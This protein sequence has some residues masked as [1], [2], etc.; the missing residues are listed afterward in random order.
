MASYV[1]SALTKGE[2]VVYQGKV[3]IWSLAPLIVLGFIF[4][5]FY[6]LGLLFWAAAAIRYL[7]TELAI[8][9]KRVI[10][11]FG[12]ISRSTIEINLQKIES[13]QVNQGILGRVFNFGSIVVS[14]A[15]NPQAPI[16]G[17]SSP[18]QFRRAFVDTQESNGQPQAVAQPA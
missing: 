17:I 2:Q 14:G 9:N 12:L 7:T 13:I 5:A 8:T 10:A 11:K 18:L 6:G 15:G 16:P 1:E 3:S 4:L